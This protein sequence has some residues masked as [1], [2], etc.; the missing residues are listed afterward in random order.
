MGFGLNSVGFS[1]GLVDFI[2]FALWVL[3]LMMSRNLY[4]LNSTLLDE[5]LS[6]LSL[7]CFS[8]CWVL[9]FSCDCN[10]NVLYI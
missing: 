4:G 6:V 5:I 7:Y 3:I 9:S 10:L 8:G 1:W 2:G